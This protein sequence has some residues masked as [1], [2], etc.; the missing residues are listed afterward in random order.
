[1]IEDATWLIENYYLLISFFN[2][3]EVIYLGLFIMTDLM[4]CVCEICYSLLRILSIKLI[5][6][7]IDAPTH[8][9]FVL[10]NFKNSKNIEPIRRPK[11]KILQTAVQ[12]L[13]QTSLVFSK[14]PELN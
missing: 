12:S 3:L 10:Q 5:Y 7:K 2:V 1:M 13:V 11:P 6:I 14:Q 9:L 4:C 8:T